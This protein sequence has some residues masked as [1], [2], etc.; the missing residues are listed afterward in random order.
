MREISLQRLQAEIFD[1]LVI[2]GGILGARISF[3]ASRAG[4][5]VALVDAGD[6]GGATSSASG[7]LVHGGLRYLRKGKVRLVC[8]AN[9]ERRILAGRVA[10]HLVRRLPF[11]LA[12]DGP[13]RRSMVAG[14]LA[15]WALDGFRRPAPRHVSAGE[16]RGLIPA[17]RT[18]D[19]A[20]CALIEEATVDDGRL[21]LATVKAAV[22]AGAEVTGRARPDR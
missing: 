9:R 1:V 15:Y 7:K 20:F 17:L 18:E 22:G 2:G 14:L 4:L 11:V 6:F 19:F 10:P 13:S 16:M 12:S 21:T 3:E 8:E 5:K